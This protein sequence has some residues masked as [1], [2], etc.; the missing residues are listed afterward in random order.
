LQEPEY[1]ERV[2]ESLYKGVAKYAGGLSGTR[3][4]AERASTK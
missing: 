4:P 2:A 3:P 1:R